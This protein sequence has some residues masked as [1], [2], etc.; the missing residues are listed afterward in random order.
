MSNNSRP[1]FQRVLAAFIEVFGKTVDAKWPGLRRAAARMVVDELDRFM[2]TAERVDLAVPVI[3][4]GELE[5]RLA[6]ASSCFRGEL[7][8]EEEPYPTEGITFT[9][10]VH[11][12][13]IEQDALDWGW[14][15]AQLQVLGRAIKQD[16]N[17]TISTQTGLE[18]ES[19]HRGKHIEQSSV[20]TAKSRHLHVFKRPQTG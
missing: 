14:S 11:L 8:G 17:L 15:P 7:L 19:T 1:V 5:D 3:I 10:L 12:V 9:A 13:R 16:E 6:R 4:L 20:R 2:S 18:V